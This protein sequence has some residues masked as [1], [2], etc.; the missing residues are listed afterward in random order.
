VL[1]NGDL[2]EL[3]VEERDTEALEALQSIDILHAEN[4]QDYTL[5]FRFKE[6][7]FFSNAYLDKTFVHGP[8]GE[9]ARAEGTKIEWKEGKNLTK[10][11]VK[12]V[13]RNSLIVRNKR[14]RDLG[15]SE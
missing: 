4:K 6:N 2:D 1:K 10:K 15:N 9:V 7:A 8:K 13:T 3:K 5:R 12:K 11:M 14:T